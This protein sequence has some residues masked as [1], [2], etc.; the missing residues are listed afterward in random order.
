[1]ALSISVIT[2]CVK[3]GLLTNASQQNIC[4]FCLAKAEATVA[5]EEPKLKLFKITIPSQ[6]LGARNVHRKTKKLVVGEIT[7]YGFIQGR[8]IFVLA[9][10]HSRLWDQCL[11]EL[12]CE[13]Q[14]VDLKVEEIEGPFEHGYVIA[15]TQPTGL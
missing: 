15:Y 12:E 3:C 6:T 5:I 4:N 10:D 7:D 14:E 8:E 1:M 13:A 11:R 9:S 2:H